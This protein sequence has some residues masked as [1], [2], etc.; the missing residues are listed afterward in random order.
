M[1]RLSLIFLA[2]CILAPPGCGRRQ[3]ETYDLV[4]KLPKGRILEYDVSTTTKVTDEM[5]TRSSIKFRITIR[6]AHAGLALVDT[7]LLEYPITFDGVESPP[8]S[9]ASQFF[10]LHTLLSEKEGLDPYESLAQGQ[11]NLFEMLFPLPDRQVA[12]GDEWPMKMQLMSLTGPGTSD[13]S[14]VARLRRVR[15]QDGSKVALVKCRSKGDIKD[16]DEGG[17]VSMKATGSATFD[18]TKGHFDSNELAVTGKMVFGPRDKTSMKT[19]VSVAL[20]RAAMMEPAEVERLAKVTDVRKVVGLA[21]Q[22]ARENKLEEALETI[23]AVLDAGIPEEHAHLI[24][25]QL[26]AGLE[27]WSEA[28]EAIETELQ[29]FGE[30]LQAL[31]LASYIYQQ[32]DKPEKANDA[33]EKLKEIMTRGQNE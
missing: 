15:N 17:G 29:H 9:V 16:P 19:T 23:N 6:A 22:L 12:L 21:I 28:E 20:A 26:H 33:Q 8:M 13:E 1:K 24:A 3:D 27:Q 14:S 25:A 31:S 2:L 32:L 30:S 11:R 18:I 5:P 10:D 4:W 7:S